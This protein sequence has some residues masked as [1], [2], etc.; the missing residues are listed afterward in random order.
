MNGVW[1]PLKF[2]IAFKT[3][4]TALDVLILPD[5]KFNFYP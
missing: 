5:A 1:L 4:F 3:H 2:K